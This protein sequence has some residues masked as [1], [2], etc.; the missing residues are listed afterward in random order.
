[1]SGTVDGLIFY[2][3]SFVIPNKIRVFP[4]FENDDF[5]YTDYFSFAVND[6]ILKNFCKN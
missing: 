6:G 5:C 1:M 2:T 4:L 3:C